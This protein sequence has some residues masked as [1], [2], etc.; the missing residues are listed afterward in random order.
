MI[1]WMYFPN[2]TKLPAFLR[3]IIDSFENNE[4]SITSDKHQLNSDSVLKT[5]AAN[6]VAAGYLVEQSKSKNDLIRV[7]VLYGENGK[8]TLSFEVDAYHPGNRTVIEVEAGRGVVNYQFLK[9]FYECCM[10]QDVDYLCI[11]VRKDYRKHKD[12]AAVCNFFSSLYA[13]GRMSIPLKGILIIG[14]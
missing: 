11:A 10:M 1:K 13:S 5:I 2:S 12:F 9:D 6:L 14:Y 7:P 4:D 3:P 8:E